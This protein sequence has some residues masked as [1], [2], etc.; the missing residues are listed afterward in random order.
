MWRDERYVR[1]GLI[2]YQKFYTQ[3]MRCKTLK[4]F[5][6]FMHSPYYTAF[7]KFGRHLVNINA[8]EADGFI[9]FLLKKE[10]LKLDDWC[11][12]SFYA[13]WV[14]EL[15]RKETPDRALE[16]NLLLM[17]KWG[18]EHDEEWTEFYRKISPQLATRWIETGKISP[19]LLYTSVGQQLMDRLSDEQLMMIKE[20]INPLF[21]K[22]KFK[23]HKEEMKVVD[24]VLKGAGL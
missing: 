9:D 23:E 11:Q 2:A 21:W 17:E 24:Q 5:E 12:D 16:R 13:E 7:T 8:L 4:T 6:E 10:K 15:S 3:V 18:I 1:Y 14:R 19:W 20:I 22:D